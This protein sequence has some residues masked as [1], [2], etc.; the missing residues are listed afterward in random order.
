ML[1]KKVVL[2]FI[3]ILHTLFLFGQCPDNESVCKQIQFL[4]SHGQSI[5]LQDQEKE[6]QAYV[7]G[8]RGCRKLDDSTIILLLQ[9]LGEI[10]I[11]QSDYVQAIKYLQHTVNL[12]LADPTKPSINYR[13]IIRSYYRLSRAY[14]YLDRVGERMTALDS[15]E[16]IARR[17]NT[18]DKFCMAALYER[19]QHF[20]D[21]GDYHRC[22]DHASMCEK[23]SK[24][25][26]K[27]GSVADLSYATSYVLSSLSW[28]INASISLK[29]YELAN[30]LLI[31]ESKENLLAGRRDYFST[32]YEQHAVLQIQKG[33][34][35]EAIKFFNLS[36]SYDESSGNFIGCKTTL[37]NIGYQIYFKH[38]NDFERALGCYRKALTY[39]NKDK[40]QDE[41]NNIETLDVY[42]NIAN[43]YKER[44]EFDSSIK[45]FQYAFDQIKPGIDES[46]LL[47]SSL[48]AFVNNR[49]IYYLTELFID[50]GDAYLGKFK[51]RGDKPAIQEAIRIY[52][53][54]DRILEKLRTEQFEVQSKLFWR[55]DTRRLYE[56]AIEACFA[57]NSTEDAFYFFERSRAVLLNDQLLEQS[58]MGQEDI[59]RQTQVR[60]KIL[61]LER[62]I[63]ETPDTS[64][65]WGDLQNDLFGGQQE[66]D[67]LNQVI[68]IRNP[69]YYQSNLDSTSIMLKDV[70]E[71]LLRDHNALME[72]F[73]GDSA[74]YSVVITNEKTSLN[75][76]NRMAYEKLSSSYNGYIL[77][78]DV[79]NRDFKGFKET[80]FA[81]YNL[82]FEKTPL[83]TGR[84]IISTDGQY[85]PFEA[86]L[87]SSSMDPPSFFL[88]DHAISYT[89]S[90]RYLMNPFSSASKEPSKEF[91]GIAPETFPDEF[92][93][94]ALPGSA[95][96]LSDLKTFF[97]LADNYVSIAATKS[98]FLR[99]FPNYA[100]I[101]LYAH[102]TDSGQNGEP[103]IYFRD[104]TLNLSD[105]ITENKPVT[106]LV[107]LGACETGSGK[108]YPGE[109]I[110]SFNRGFAAVG[111]PSSIV[112]LGAV[113]NESSYKITESF[114]RFL[115]QGQPLDVALQKAK[116]DF[117][118]NSSKEKSLP[119]FW[120]L[121]I[122][123]GK[124]DPIVITRSYI[125]IW[126]PIFG[127][128]VF[129]LL[130][131]VWKIYAMK[132]KNSISFRGII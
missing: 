37:N 68:K 30:T 26:L 90:A 19:A 46:G 66:L 118:K 36:L 69:L 58:W 8:A 60:K 41:L 29:D 39:H 34:Y 108:L 10:Y 2:A 52:R 82:I 94:A 75:R 38:F 53:V 128:V 49:K 12:T 112:N 42:A 32:I 43:V 83:P 115:A 80:S 105:L 51:V 131:W 25:F 63:R 24:E 61:Q 93:L 11:D 97:K 98:N 22:F 16:T 127:I 62:D 124:S 47:N 86:L 35:Q 107:V 55:M 84:I 110:F 6:L 9:R 106:R 104:S 64:K 129:G 117:I 7:V 126:Y 74:V 116:I 20:F 109:G 50:K 99:L 113:D 91:L 17:Y 87:K 27:K 33:N 13:H 18:E 130:F 31:E 77:H 21:I 59:L 3:F 76:I 114:Y 122:L 70:R 65:K 121:T 79:L 28:M 123:S 15:C 95:Q 125:W 72:I 71:Y 119:G 78:S 73:V 88:Y 101:Q 92:A 81:L 57:G 4:R 44:G 23:L 85:F 120:A 14:D 89:P 102:A 5:S 1:L 40:S 132:N 100:I 56:H 67:R 111:I 45:Y 54:T 48:D 103:M 96:S